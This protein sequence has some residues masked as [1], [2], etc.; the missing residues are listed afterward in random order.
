MNRFHSAAPE[1]ELHCALVDGRIAQHHDDIEDDAEQYA[2]RLG[3]LGLFGDS[4]EHDAERL[5]YH[6]LGEL[7]RFRNQPMAQVS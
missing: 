6:G 7:L 2:E 1:R 5:Q 4:G 3:D